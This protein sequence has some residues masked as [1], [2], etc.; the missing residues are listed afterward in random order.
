MLPF[1]IIALYLFFC[2]DPDWV[3]INLGLLCCINCSGIHRSLGVGFSKVRSVKLDAID[4]EVFLVCF[5]FSF[6]TLRRSC[7]YFI[8]FD[9]S[10]QELEINMSMKFMKQ[11]FLKDNIS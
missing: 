11:T 4:P 7:F 1:I 6:S 3:A 9:S 8:C 2:T 5:Y 10:L